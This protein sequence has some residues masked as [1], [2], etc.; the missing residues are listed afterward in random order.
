MSPRRVR[1]S[2]VVGGH[3]IAA[4]I[5][6]L[7][8][9]RGVSGSLETAPISV[10]DPN[11]VYD[12]VLEGEILPAGYGIAL[13]RDAILPVYEPAFTRAGDVDWPGDM[14]V[15]GVAGEDTAKGLPGHAPELS[16]DGG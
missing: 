15:I 1:Y 3:V 10:P 12:P 2:L 16:R 7:V 14:L 9:N 6:G 13:P 4:A 8:V 11:T 5:T